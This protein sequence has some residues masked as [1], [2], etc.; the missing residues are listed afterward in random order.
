MCMANLAQWHDSTRQ[1]CPQLAMSPTAIASHCMQWRQWDSQHMN[2]RTWLWT[3]MQTVQMPVIVTSWKDTS[4]TN[5]RVCPSPCRFKQSHMAC[6]LM[7]GD[8]RRTLFK[9]V[10]HRI[11]AITRGC[12]SMQCWRLFLVWIGINKPEILIFSV[13]ANVAD[14]W[15]IHQ[16]FSI[17]N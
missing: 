9:A 1:L 3:T 12:S 4:T 11:L 14:V 2:N 5:A 6:Q 7:M 17:E 16:S 15:Y 10:N 13:D 8:G